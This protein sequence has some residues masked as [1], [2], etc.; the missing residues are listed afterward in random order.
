[1][2]LVPANTHWRSNCTG[3]WN[4]LG[5]AL[6]GLGRYDEAIAA[7]QKSLAHQEEV[8]RREPGIAGRAQSLDEQMRHLCWL[9]LKLGRPADAAKLAR[10]RKDLWPGDPR[11]AATAAGELAFAALSAPASESIF[12][13]LWE[14]DR[15]DYAALAIAAARDAARLLA[16]RS[17]LAETPP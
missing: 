6:E 13:L 10:Q 14:R 4:R 1:M 15:R 8:Y 16:R 17:I 7:N 12:S 5:E 3:S 2:L 11:V 9:Y